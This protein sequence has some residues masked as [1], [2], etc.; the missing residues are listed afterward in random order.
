V[1]LHKITEK[2]ISELSDGS[3]LYKDLESLRKR[4]YKLNSLVDNLEIEN[5]CL[6][7][8]FNN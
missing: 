2:L 5:F 1:A 4:A 6:P 8:N 3:R 7:K